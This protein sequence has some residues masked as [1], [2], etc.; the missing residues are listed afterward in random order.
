VSRPAPPAISIRGLSFTYRGAARPALEGVDLNLEAG[1]WGLLLGPTGA[2]K[3]TLVRCLNRVI[4]QFYP[5][6]LGG[7]I[8]LHGADTSGAR[9]P[10]LAARV[11]VVFQDFESQIFCTSCLLEVSFAMENRC[12]EPGPMRR[13]AAELLARV[14]LSGFEARDP[15]TLSGGEKQRLV[16]ASVLALEAP[17]MVLDEPA[18]D[19]DPGGRHEIYRLLA[20]LENESVL[21]VDH[22]LEGVPPARGTLL[23]R[24]RCVRRWDQGPAGSMIAL[25][26]ELEKH[27]VRPPPLAALAAMLERKHGRAPDARV[28]EP[29]PF[30]AAM[31]AEGWDVEPARASPASSSPTPGPEI[32]RCERVTHVYAGGP[33]GRPALDRIELSIRQGEMIAVIGANGSGKTTLARHLNGLLRATTGR[34][35]YKGEDVRAMPARRRA[36]EIGFVFQD[37]DHQIFAGTVREEAA[38]GPANLGLSPRDVERR[39]A[40]A[41]EA[42]DLA[43]SESADPFT[44]TKGERQRLALASVLACEPSLIIMDEPT[45]GLDLGQQR[46]VMELLGRLNAAGHTILIIT[47]ALWLV[48]EPVRRV[49]VMKEGRLAGDGTPRELMTDSPLMEGA[50]LRLPDLARLGALWRAPLLRLEEWGVAIVPPSARA[51]NV[52]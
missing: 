9:V 26:G 19:L 1:R 24:G 51:G 12:L 21:L 27:G 35:L 52:G 31:Q 16:I 8:L 7:E 43:G 36:M 13:R 48:A 42:V 47:H 23:A 3:S 46:R 14:G 41:L 20:S 10:D 22:D 11:G 5:G 2:G 37:P 15:A 30:H 28:L 25:A 17:L 33:D 4:P 39:V 44:L 49:L 40:M 45:T 32:L 6:E 38:F 50:G 29:E 34:V 18:S